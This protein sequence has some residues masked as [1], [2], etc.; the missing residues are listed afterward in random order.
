MLRTSRRTIKDE[1]Y[2]RKVLQKKQTTRCAVLSH[3]SMVL[4]VLALGITILHSSMCRETEF[5]C[6]MLDLC[7]WQ[8][9]GQYVGYHFLSRAVD[10]PYLSI[11]DDP[12]YEVKTNVDMLSLGMILVL[13]HERDCRLIIGE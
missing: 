13:L 1:K 11:F 10:Q 7:R 2:S 9:F 8:C 3:M 5:T 12:T 6:E 4:F